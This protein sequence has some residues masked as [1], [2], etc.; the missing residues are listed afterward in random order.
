MSNAIYNFIDGLG[1]F[2]YGHAKLR[3]LLPAFTTSS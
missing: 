1:N 2:F 3:M